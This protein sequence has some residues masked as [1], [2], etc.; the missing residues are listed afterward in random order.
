MSSEELSTIYNLPIEI[1]EKYKT[2]HGLLPQFLK[3]L[4]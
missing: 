4:K 2:K 3:Q 1:I